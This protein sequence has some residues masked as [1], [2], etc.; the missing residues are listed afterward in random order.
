[1][2]A[3]TTATAAGDDDQAI[4]LQLQHK[5][6]HEAR[7]TVFEAPVD[8]FLRLAKNQTTSRLLT[9]LSIE[10]GGCRIDKKNLNR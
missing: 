2:A 10:T 3:A 8:S 1:M 7:P 6:V 9:Q 5:T 4:Q